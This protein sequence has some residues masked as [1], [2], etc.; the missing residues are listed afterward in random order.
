L[1]PFF[2]R[3]WNSWRLLVA[4]VI[5]IDEVYAK[6]MQTV[7]FAKLKIESNQ[8][9]QMVS[10]QTKNPNLGI[11]GRTLE[12]K[13]LLYILVISNILVALGM[14]CWYFVIV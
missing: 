1:A 3:T 10:F 11:F 4:A 9:C 5:K 7:G 14:F 2:T 6:V 12:R 8:G 13:M